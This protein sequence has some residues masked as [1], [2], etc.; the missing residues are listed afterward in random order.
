M[1][2]S[3]WT[4]PALEEVKMDAEIGSYQADEGRRHRMRRHLARELLPLFTQRYDLGEVIDSGL[5]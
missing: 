2:K 1:S 5:R 4:T 3:N